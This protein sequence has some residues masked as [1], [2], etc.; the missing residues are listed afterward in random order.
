MDV[1]VFK[2]MEEFLDYD[3]SQITAEDVESLEKLHP[4]WFYEDARE[5]ALEGDDTNHGS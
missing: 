2:S 4:E 1:S 5:Y 3:D